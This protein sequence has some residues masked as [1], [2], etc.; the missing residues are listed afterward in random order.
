MFSAMSRLVFDQIKGYRS[1]AQLAHKSNIT[2]LKTFCILVL[3]IKN[4]CQ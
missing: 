4:E 2:L 1:L 3:T